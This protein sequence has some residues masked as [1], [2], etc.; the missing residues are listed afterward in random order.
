MPSIKPSI[1]LF[2]SLVAIFLVFVDQLLKYKI[3]QTGG[4]YI[5]NNG[6]SFGLHVPYFNF[7]LILG[8]LIF[9]IL[10]VIFFFNKK[11]FNSD[12][13]LL[14]MVFVASGA[15]SN[16]FDRLYLGCVS[17]YI[18]PSWKILP[19]VNLADISIF[20]GSCLIIFALLFKKAAG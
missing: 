5:C 19:L 12:F 16:L 2:I 18:F 13:L 17:D 8:I 9:F 4:F 10:L 3:R 11:R 7:W 1:F 6:I 14:G 20:F 15:T